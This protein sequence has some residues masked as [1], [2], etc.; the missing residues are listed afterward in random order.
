MRRFP[1]KALR[2]DD[3]NELPVLKARGPEASR[4]SI[5][6]QQFWHDVHHELTAEPNNISSNMILL[7]DLIWLQR[8]IL[9][10]DWYPHSTAK[11]H[12]AGRD[13]DH[14]P[15]NL[16][17]T[18]SMNSKIPTSRHQDQR[19]YRILACSLS[20]YNSLCLCSR[21]HSRSRLVSYRGTPYLLI[22]IYASTYTHC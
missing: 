11:A 18:S 7:Y 20:S 17:S 9:T 3:D 4:A 21:S 6:H 10:Y 22:I 8:R 2:K 16:Y 12:E 14:Y 1:D 19:I 13:E 15:W 5:R